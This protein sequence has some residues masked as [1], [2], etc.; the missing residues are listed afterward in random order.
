[1]TID[2]KEFKHLL[3]E[4]FLHQRRQALNNPKLMTTWIDIYCLL[5]LG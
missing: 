5:A 3:Y 2:G 1:M 4:N